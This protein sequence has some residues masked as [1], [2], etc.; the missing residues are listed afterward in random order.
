MGCSP[1]LAKV[2]EGGHPMSKERAETHEPL[3]TADL[4]L[5][6]F[7]YDCIEGLM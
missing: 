3:A 7:E 4:W 2:K 1:L 5:Q 6:K